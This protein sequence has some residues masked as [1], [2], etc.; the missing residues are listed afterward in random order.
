MSTPFRIPIRAFHKDRPIIIQ[1]RPE[2]VARTSSKVPFHRSN[3]MLQPDEY[4]V[5]PHMLI[6][7]PPS[8]A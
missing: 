3:A 8:T 6:I 7:P 5:L 1:T 2:G 4:K